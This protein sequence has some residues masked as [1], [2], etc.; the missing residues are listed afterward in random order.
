MSNETA[1]WHG[2]SP[3]ILCGE[4]SNARPATAAEDAM[5]QQGLWHEQVARD[6]AVAGLQVVMDRLP[7][8]GGTPRLKVD[9]ARLL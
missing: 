3:H 7:Q 6:A 9:H 1:G 2:E 5:L 4:T 8:A